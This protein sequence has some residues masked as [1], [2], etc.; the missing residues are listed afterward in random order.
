MHLIK[1][2]VYYS[3]LV[4]FRLYPILYGFSVVLYIQRGHWLPNLNTIKFFIVS[5]GLFISLVS[6]AYFCYGY[7][8]L[9]EWALYHLVR[10]DPRHSQSI[11]W[12]RQ[13]YNMVQGDNIPIN[14]VTLVFR[15]GA[16][17]WVSFKFRSNIVM[18]IF[19]NTMIFT[20]F[21]T[22]YTAQ[23]AI[24]EIQLLPLIF[25]QTNLWTSGKLKFF[26]L[27]VFWL[28]I[29]ELSITCGGLYENS[30]KT[31]L[32]WMHF[33]NILYV[34]YRVYVIKFVLDSRIPYL[35]Y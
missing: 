2:A 12:M 21:N 34:F 22:V 14:L 24:W 9:Y 25:K 5:A 3:L 8:F 33:S 10:K 35:D 18:A 6:V 26:V 7:K 4:H 1:A 13:M 32:Y 30:G 29:M 15:L 20:I 28:V 11:F 16:I 23:Y 17:V 27:M 31:T 19:I